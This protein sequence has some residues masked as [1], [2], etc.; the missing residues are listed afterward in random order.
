MI[1]DDAASIRGA[2]VYSWKWR[3]EWAGSGNTS[4]EVGIS[5]CISVVS[6]GKSV[7]F[8]SFYKQYLPISYS[9]VWMWMSQMLCSRP[10]WS[11]FHK[12]WDFKRCEDTLKEHWI[13]ECTG[14]SPIL[15]DSILWLYQGESLHFVWSVSA[16]LG[17]ALT[18]VW[19]TA[20]EVSGWDLRRLPHLGEI[21]ATF[22]F[23]CVFLQLPLISLSLK[24][25]TQSF[26]LNTFV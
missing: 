5:Y 1:I 13:T 14:S 15:F 24:L 21:L 2:S 4:Y 11:I 26:L 12:L 6:L 3:K 25:V 16:P 18:S 19:L 10:E 20:A 17:H 9:G 7:D 8:H 23:H 22:C